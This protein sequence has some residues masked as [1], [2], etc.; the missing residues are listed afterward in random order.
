MNRHPARAW[1]PSVPS[2]AITASMS[3]MDTWSTTPASATDVGAVRWRMFLSRAS[4]ASGF[5]SSTTRDTSTAAKWW[6]APARAWR[7]L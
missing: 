7:N 5:A 4:R 6:R 1:L 3:A 2:V